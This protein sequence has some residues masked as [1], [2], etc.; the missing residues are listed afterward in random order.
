MQNAQPGGCN[1]QS[2]VTTRGRLLQQVAACLAHLFGTKNHSANNVT[3]SATVEMDE[4]CQQIGFVSDKWET[5]RQKPCIAHTKGI[6]KDRYFSRQLLGK[7]A[8]ANSTSLLKKFQISSKHLD[9]LNGGDWW[10]DETNRSSCKV[11]Y[12]LLCYS[13]H[14][15]AI[16]AIISMMQLWRC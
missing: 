4:I 3:K 10:L 5:S 11:F 13:W 16:P 12:I 9:I 2:P 15:A 1:G 14:W 7:F 8:S 6:C